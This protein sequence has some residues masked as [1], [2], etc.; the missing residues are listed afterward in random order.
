MKMFKQYLL[1]KKF[2]FRTDHAA[3]QWLQ[4][5]PEPIGQHGRWLERLQEFDYQVVHRPG[6][7]HAKADSLT[8]RPRRQCD[9]CASVVETT[10]TQEKRTIRDVPISDPWCKESSKSKSQDEDEEICFIKS[11][12]KP[13]WESILSFGE[14]I[15][16]YWHM[17]N[18][19][20][21]IDGVLY[22]KSLTGKRLMVLPK[23]L[24]KD[25]FKMIHEDLTN[26]QFSS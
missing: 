2:V 25:L 23:T 17:W 15:K 18:D 24:Q 21:I 16:T 7:N 8:R 13:E 19:L 1:G 5:T 14:V 10:E 6:R 9:L 3:L 4:R 12:T 26:G 11:E 22:K 20:Q